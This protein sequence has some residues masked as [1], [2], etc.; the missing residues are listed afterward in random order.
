MG[1]RTLHYG[2]Q[3]NTILLLLFNI[4]LGGLAKEI[5]WKKKKKMRGIAVGREVSKL[6]FTLTN[7]DKSQIMVHYLT[8][9]EN[10]T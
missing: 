6:L 2:C 7:P 4:I 1:I 8:S 3:Y 10:G 5:I 9:D